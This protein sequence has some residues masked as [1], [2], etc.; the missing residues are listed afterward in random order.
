MVGLGRVALCVMRGEGVLTK[1]PYVQVNV[2]IYFILKAGSIITYK[3]GKLF[4]ST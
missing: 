4:A 3:L 2:N 1:K